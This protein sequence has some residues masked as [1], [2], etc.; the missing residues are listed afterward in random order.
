MGVIHSCNR[1]TDKPVQN[2]TLQ[3][4]TKLL[5]LTTSF[6]TMTKIVH[7]KNKTVHIVNKNL[8]QFY[9]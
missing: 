8:I 1:M 7:S 2:L 3:L 9:S 6:D 5:S 4:M